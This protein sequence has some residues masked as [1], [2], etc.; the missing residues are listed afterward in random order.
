MSG[1]TANVDR[2]MDFVATVL[3]CRVPTTIPEIMRRTGYSRA[4]TYRLINRMRN[5]FPLEVIEGTSSFDPMRVK[6]GTV[7][8]LGAQ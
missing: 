4:N 1:R 8:S 7:R 5:H 2:V 3:A 6:K